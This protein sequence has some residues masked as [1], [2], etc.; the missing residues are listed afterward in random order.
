MLEL[1]SGMAS[2]PSVEGGLPRLQRHPSVVRRPPAQRAQASAAPISSRTAHACETASAPGF[3]AP[4]SPPPQPRP[5][6]E[7]HEPLAFLSQIS[8]HHLSHDSQPHLQV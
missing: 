5:P 2:S 8:H 3:S 6:L 4:G 1:V 7:S